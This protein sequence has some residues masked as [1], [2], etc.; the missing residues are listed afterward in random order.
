[1]N[2]HA[3]YDVCVLVSVPSQVVLSK[4]LRKDKGLMSIATKI[5]IQLNCKLGGEP[6]VLKVPVSVWR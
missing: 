2:I 6:W 1:M 5:G 4:T 3:H